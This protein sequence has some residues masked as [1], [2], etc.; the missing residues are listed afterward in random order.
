MHWSY[1]LST[2]WGA[3]EGVRELLQNLWDGA[4]QNEVHGG[5]RSPVE[6]EVKESSKAVRKQG[7]KTMDIFFDGYSTRSRKGGHEKDG[8]VFKVHYS[9]SS[10]TLKLINYDVSLPKKILIIGK[11]SKSKNAHTIGG[12]GEG[13]KMGQLSQA[14]YVCA[15]LTDSNS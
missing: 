1:G 2:D 9:P 11:T 5:D 12:H 4:I 8:R 15:D 10:R 14:M 13:L 6:I 7:V 3:A